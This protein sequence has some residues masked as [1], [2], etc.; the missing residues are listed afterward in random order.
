MGN[1]QEELNKFEKNNEL[2][3]S[4][5]IGLPLLACRLAQNTAKIKNKLSTITEGDL[6]DFLIKDLTQYS[7]TLKEE[8]CVGYIFIDKYIVNLKEK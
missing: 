8:G 4:N 5:M 3:L 1:F 2:I 6:N 7:Q